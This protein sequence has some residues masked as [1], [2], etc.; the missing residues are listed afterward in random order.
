[1]ELLHSSWEVHSWQANRARRSSKSQRA[2]QNI[3]TRCLADGAKPKNL[4]SRADKFAISYISYCGAAVLPIHYQKS[5][6]WYCAGQCSLLSRSLLCSS[7]G[8][9]SCIFCVRRSILVHLISHTSSCQ[10]ISLF[11]S[12]YTQHRGFSV[13]IAA[14]WSLIAYSCLRQ[15][16]HHSKWP[17]Y[18]AI[19]AANA[20]N[21]VIQ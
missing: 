20:T 14:A 10:V 5:G 3:D 15:S 13:L 19:V 11:N 16:I 18:A 21:T 1:M 7:N 2:P 17:R 12:D 4:G 6:F 8:C 9:A